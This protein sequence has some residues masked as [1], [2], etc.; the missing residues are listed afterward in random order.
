MGAEAGLKGVG[1]RVNL[2]GKGKANLKRRG[3]GRQ[4][5]GVG[6]DSRGGGGVST[7]LEGAR[8]NWS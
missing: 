3:G 1:E 7:V 8:I 2:K 5:G 4:R 6:A